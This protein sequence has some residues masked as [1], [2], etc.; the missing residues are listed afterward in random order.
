MARFAG[1]KKAEPKVPSADSYSF[2]SVSLVATFLV[3]QEASLR[4]QL[5]SCGIDASLLLL[6]PSA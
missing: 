3:F 1:P 6:Q 5:L 2:V 4:T